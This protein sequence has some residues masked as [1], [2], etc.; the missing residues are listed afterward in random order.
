VANP[1][2]TIIDDDR[3]LCADLEVVLSSL[4][5]VSIANDGVSGLALL[6][7]VQPE[8]VLLDVE[9]LDSDMGGLEILERIMGLDNKPTV[10]MLTGRKDVKT[11]VQAMKAGAFDY[12]D[13]PAEPAKLVNILSKA[14]VSRYRLR[15]I[16][17]HRDEVDRLACT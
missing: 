17:A 13:K 14:L 1:L 12:L 4:Y 9:F 5:Q 2:L 15:Q 7:D 10:V 8:L 6:A 16:Q 11:V 3:D